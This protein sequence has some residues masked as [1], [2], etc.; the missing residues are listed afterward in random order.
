M[1]V[2]DVEV[3]TGVSGNWEKL[4]KYSHRKTVMFKD[5][6]SELKVKW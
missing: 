5:A 4:M 2:V 3:R 1:S 6:S